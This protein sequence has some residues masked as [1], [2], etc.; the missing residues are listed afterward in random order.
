MD[1]R[2]NQ[3]PQDSPQMFQQA[4]PKKNVPTWLKVVGI[5]FLVGLLVNIF[6]KDDNVAESEAEA[7][8]ANAEVKPKIDEALVA[9]L[10]S[11]FNTKTDE[12]TGETW[13]EHKGIPKHRNKNNIY[14]YFALQDGK[15]INP[16]LV[17][18]YEG[19]DWLFVKDCIIMSD[20]GKLVASG[21]FERD[22]NSRV[23][24]W[25]DMHLTSDQLQMLG[26]VA[27]GEGFKMRYNGRQY[28]HDR[29][30][31]KKEQEIIKETLDYY[32]AL[33]GE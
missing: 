6:G 5:F 32:Y 7:A 15:P 9:K 20:M 21:Q 22:N 26:T 19:S 28:Y 23:W 33:G 14:T 8:T 3:M 27:I 10:Q 12:F 17:I 24:E 30:I 1:N 18:Q 31:T 13:V 4:K 25:L 2:I 29:N 11:H 16:R